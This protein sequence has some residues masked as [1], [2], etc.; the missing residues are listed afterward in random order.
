MRD[1]VVAF[2]EYSEELDERMM[3]MRKKSLKFSVWITK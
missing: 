2:E 3:V 1:T